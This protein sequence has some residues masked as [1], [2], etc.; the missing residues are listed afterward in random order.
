MLRGLN[1][2]VFKTVPILREELGFCVLKDVIN[3]I[4]NPAFLEHRKAMIV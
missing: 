1:E 4:V 2:T 3:M